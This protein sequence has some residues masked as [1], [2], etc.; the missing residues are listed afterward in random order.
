MSLSPIGTEPEK[1]KQSASSCK[2]SE[3]QGTPSCSSSALQASVQLKQVLAMSPP[4]VSAEGVESLVAGNIV[5]PGQMPEASS[6]IGLSEVQSVAKPEARPE[7]KVNPWIIN[8]VLDLLFSCGGIVWLFFGLHYFVFGAKSHELPVQSLVVM[9]ILGTHFLSESHNM[10]TL[11]RIFQKEEKDRFSFF[12]GKLAAYAGTLAIIGIVFPPLVPIMTKIYLI[13][14][15]Q[16]F[17]AQTYGLALLYCYK[18]NYF[19]NNF[20]KNIFS[21]LMWCTTAFAIVRQFTYADWGGGNFLGQTIPFWG[22]LPESVF[23]F[24][25]ALLTGIA[26][27]FAIVVLRKAAVEKKVFP[28]PALL[29]TVTGIL[30]WICGKDLTGTLWLYVPAFYHGSQYLLVSAG[31]YLKE[32]GLVEGGSASAMSKS[33]FQPVGLKYFAALAMLAIFFY[34]GIPHMLEQ[35]GFSFDLVFAAI[36]CSI[37]FHHFLTDAAIWK[38]R[39]KRNREIL[40]A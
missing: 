5:H 2:G 31:Y 19:F 32:K 40:L 39:D 29:M 6:E 1:E 35:M 11:H 33:L 21:A 25:S 20:E 13:W 17:T 18:R 16:H 3:L 34:V 24:V 15:S 36:F 4:V 8:P 27:M 38:L 12:S 14:V 22:P 23:S 7:A 26:A 30:I 28:L 9:V 37:N 10:A